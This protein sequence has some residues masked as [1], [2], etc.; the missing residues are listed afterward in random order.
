MVAAKARIAQKQYINNKLAKGLIKL[1][2]LFD[3]KGKIAD[4]NIHTGK[5]TMVSAKGLLFDAMMSHL[6]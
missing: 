3:N 1:F 4:L 6:L 2:V 5:S